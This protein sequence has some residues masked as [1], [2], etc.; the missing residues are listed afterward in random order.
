MVVV[1][2]PPGCRVEQSCGGAT[3]GSDSSSFENSSTP[4][5]TVRGGAAAVEFYRRAFG[6]SEIHRNT[7]ADGR[8]VAELAIGDA[9]VRVADETLES[10]DRSTATLGGTSVRLN[11]LVPDPDA[12]ATP[13]IAAGAVEIVPV[14]DQPYGLR[15]GRVRDPFGHDWL[16]GV[17]LPGPSGA[18]A[19][20]EPRSP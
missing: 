2:D 14:A 19:R 18:W 10:H 16:I 4:V 6:A 15:Q 3:R 17:P 9:R 12:F 13:A 5:L 11:L 1:P 8:I 7:Y 20:R